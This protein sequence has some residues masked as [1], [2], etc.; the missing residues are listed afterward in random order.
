MSCYVYVLHS[1]NFDRRYIGSSAEPDTRFAAHQAGKVRS[2]KAWRPWK[3]ILL[4]EHPNRSVAEKRERYLKSGSGR[5]EL[6]Q[7]L[8]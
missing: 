8:K 1:V 4:E 6:E 3:R 7:L 5:R 2:T